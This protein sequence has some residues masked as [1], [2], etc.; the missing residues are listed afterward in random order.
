MEGPIRFA[1]PSVRSSHR[2]RRHTRLPLVG[3]L[4]PASDESPS[5]ATTPTSTRRGGLP[6][7]PS[8]GSDSRHSRSRSSRRH[9]PRLTERTFVE[10]GASRGDRQ[11]ADPVR[12]RRTQPGR[13]REGP[14]SVEP[15][16][17]IR[18]RAAQ[19][20]GFS[21]CTFPVLTSPPTRLSNSSHID[22]V[23]QRARRSR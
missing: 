4:E 14:G 7:P 23:A 16:P 13:Y 2:G 20:E 17:G 1:G 5:D 22:P 12:D 9:E 6:D 8:V 21:S 18:S 19:A 10:P 11:F 15:R 3:P